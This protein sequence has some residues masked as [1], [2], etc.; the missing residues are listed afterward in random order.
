MGSGIFPKLGDHNRSL[1]SIQKA[2]AKQ[3][4]TFEKFTNGQYES[5]REIMDEIS[6][7][8]GEILQIYN[9]D[10]EYGKILVRL[11][12]TIFAQDAQL[13]VAARTVLDE[14]FKSDPT[15]P[16]GQQALVQFEEV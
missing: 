9:S 3:T 15:S 10:T 1:V 13:E 5:Q 2:L 11:F 6:A 14:F 12:Q 4:D 8:K 16:E 7:L